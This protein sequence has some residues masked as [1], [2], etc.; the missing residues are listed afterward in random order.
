MISYEPLWETMR[1]KNISQ[2][3]L[4]QAGINN[5][6]LN[7]LKNNKS[8]TMYTLEKICNVLDCE[9]NEVVTFTKED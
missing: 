2:Y 7:A 3:K 1:K 5:R 8:I 6:I 9:A 4:L